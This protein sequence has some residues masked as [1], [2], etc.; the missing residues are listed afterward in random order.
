[1]QV[2]VSGVARLG[3]I[4]AAAI[5][6]G[7]FVWTVGAH[8]GR[9]WLAVTGGDGHS[10]LYRNMPWGGVPSEIGFST[11]SFGWMVVDGQ[12]FTSRDGGVTWSE[13]TLP[14]TR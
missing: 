9:G 5:Q 1:M 8:D 11:H 10:R 4:T 6:P 12:L 14:M 3:Q 7:G 13:L 2:E